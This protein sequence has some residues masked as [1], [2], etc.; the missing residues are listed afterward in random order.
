MPV[1]LLALHPNPTWR[2]RMRLRARVLDERPAAALRAIQH[3][4]MEDGMRAN[5]NC[6]GTRVTWTRQA[7]RI[8]ELSHDGTKKGGLLHVHVG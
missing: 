3:V 2:M 4:C 5:F 7:H 8:Q 1:T 6:G